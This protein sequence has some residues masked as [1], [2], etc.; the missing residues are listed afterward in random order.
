MVFILQAIEKSFGTNASTR[1]L[2]VPQRIPIVSA[3][4]KSFKLAGLCMPSIPALGRQSL[5]DLG[6]PSLHSEFQD[7]KGFIVRLPTPE[8]FNRTVLSSFF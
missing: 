5:E 1:E 6:Q 4:K 7:S 3:D 2:S 8:S